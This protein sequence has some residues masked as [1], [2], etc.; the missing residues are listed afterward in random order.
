MSS[1]WGVARMKLP[2][3]PEETR[4]TGLV[5]VLFSSLLLVLVLVEYMFD[6]CEK[7]LPLLGSQSAR[8]RCGGTGG[9]DIRGRQGG[10]PAAT[11]FRSF[12]SVRLGL[13]YGEF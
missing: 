10:R 11:L 4:R 3:V 1:G 7:G 6:S 2:A 13:F 9:L 8:G 12:G 5:L